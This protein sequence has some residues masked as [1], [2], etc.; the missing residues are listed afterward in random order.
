MSNRRKS[1]IDR[2]A[3]SY[4]N[5]A[6]PKVPGYVPVDPS[7]PNYI[8]SSH[9]GARLA[10]GGFSRSILTLH[11]RIVRSPSRADLEAMTRDGLR[12]L[13]GERGLSGY[14]RLN[15][16]GLVEVLS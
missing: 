15:K 12:A 4:R 14:G 10:G 8:P 1:T 5:A 6:L 7:R 9:M 3:Q 13:A 11:K 2:R 16:A